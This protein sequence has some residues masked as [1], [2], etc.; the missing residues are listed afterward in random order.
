M[1]LAKTMRFQ[2]RVLLCLLAVLAALPAS[3]F[4]L[5]STALNKARRAQ[6]R[7]ESLLSQALQLEVG[8][9]TKS[10][11]QQLINQFGPAYYEPPRQYP[12]GLASSPPPAH[13]SP[14]VKINMVDACIYGETFAFVFDNSAMH[15]LGLAPLV[16]LGV[17]LSLYQ[18][19]LC[20][21]S[22]SFSSG[23]GMRR[24][25]IDIHEYWPA[26]NNT[27]W[28]QA[29]VGQL[30][31]YVDLGEPVPKD[32]RRGLYSFNFRCLSQA[33]GC[34]KSQDLL[35]WIWMQRGRSG[36]DFPE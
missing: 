31:T 28:F 24:V 25:G 16:V 3:Y 18:G 27:S 9:A 33:G 5:R 1:M 22:V 29:K 20:G 17:G 2:Y 35:P 26:P 32:I 13:P 4:L 23:T 30:Q 21:R 15:R 34:R 8:R 14:N 36:V 7:A 12:M 19:T 6:A 11:V 10:Q